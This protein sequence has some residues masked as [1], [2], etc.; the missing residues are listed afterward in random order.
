VSISWE[1]TTKSDIKK[2]QVSPTLLSKTSARSAFRKYKEQ[3][4]AGVAQVIEHLPGKCKAL[5]SNLS[6]TKKK[7]CDFGIKKNEKN[8]RFERIGI[9]LIKKRRILITLKY[10]SAYDSYASR[11]QA[12]AQKNI[13]EK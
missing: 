6:I 10:A 13:M 7:K 11:Q 3:K 4:R 2:I 1:N 5:S 12:A 8:K 9:F